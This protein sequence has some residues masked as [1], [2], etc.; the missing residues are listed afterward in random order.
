[1]STCTCHVGSG[2][3]NGID[4]ELL[5]WRGT[6]KS[7]KGASVPTKHGRG[8]VECSPAMDAFVHGSVSPRF[9]S[10]SSS[11]RRAK[12]HHARRP[13]RPSD[14]PEENRN[15]P[16]ALRTGCRLHAVQTDAASSA[17]KDDALGA[18][19]LAQPRPEATAR[20]PAD[21]SA[22]NASAV[23]ARLEPSRPGCR[24]SQR[25]STVRRG[26]GSTGFPRRARILGRKESGRRS[27]GPW[28]STVCARRA[29]S[30]KSRS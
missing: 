26:Q 15:E 21:L 28:I 22:T 4:R 27:S 17:M 24:A 18:S 7:H 10:R 13:V 5:E 3:G 23:M 12:K 2:S 9:P 16:A 30:A 6:P 14:T 19:R 20:C 1:V 29:T 25:T 8:D 11:P